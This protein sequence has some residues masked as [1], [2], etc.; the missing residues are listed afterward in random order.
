MARSLKFIAATPGVFGHVQR[1]PRSARN[2][3]GRGP[4]SYTNLSVYAFGLSA[5]WISINMVLLQ[6]RVLDIADED[7]KNGML[8]AIAL[9]GLVVAALSQ[10]LMGAL[11]DRTNSRWGKRLPYIV[12]GNICLIA[13]APLLGIADSFVSLLIVIVLIQLF[14]HVSQGPANALLLD[15]IPAHRRGAG[16]GALN[17]ARVV[18]GGFI[19]LVVMLL[20]SRSVAG[21]GPSAWYW[22][23]IGLVMVILAL[24]TL[25]TF[26]S[27]RP[28]QK[29]GGAGRSE[30]GRYPGDPYRRS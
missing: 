21:E 8:G 15:H 7:H 16:A 19:T 6:F 18:G 13:V 4:D 10:P 11:S 25:W 23:S 20:M 2:V 3:Y 1:F 22:T 9:A 30:R 17:L 28:R 27:L 29:A 12:A 24:T 26:G 14:I 5:L